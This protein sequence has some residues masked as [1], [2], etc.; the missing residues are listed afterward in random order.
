MQRK[1]LRIPRQ[2]TPQLC[3]ASRKRDYQTIAGSLDR[4]ANM[5]RNLSG[6]NLPHCRIRLGNHNSFMLSRVHQLAK[7]PQH[8]FRFVPKAPRS[9]KQLRQQTIQFTMSVSG[10]IDRPHIQT[11]ASA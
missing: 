6:Q 3:H 4:D 9:L 8:F 7:L 1:A 10:R 2:T 5:L 11:T